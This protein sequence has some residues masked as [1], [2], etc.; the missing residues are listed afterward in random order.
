MKYAILLGGIEINSDN[1]GISI[2]E[3]GNG[4]NTATIA[5]G[6]YYL[7]GDGAS[8]DFCLALKTALEAASASANTY[9]VTVTTDGTT[10]SWDTNPAN[11]S[12]KVRIARLTGSATFEI[13]WLDALTTFDESLLGFAVEKGAADANPEVSTLSPEA[14][15]VSSQVHRDIIRSAS[16]DLA[17]IKVNSGDT[18]TIK[19]SKKFKQAQIVSMWVD[20]RR[21]LASSSP[22]DE[23]AAMESFIDRFSA[24]QPIEAH[25]Q[26]LLSSAVTT[27]SALSSSTSIGGTWRISDESANFVPARE[28]LGLDLFNFD[29]FLS[30]AV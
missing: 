15:W 24:G 4:T 20:A 19:R 27:L 28:M 12:A 8:G 6:T 13:N 10:A 21:V 7:R 9:G 30:G 14:V 23:G 16:W 3:T 5:A 29:T 1:W 17:S 11:V 18:R 25:E 26:T 2:T 22:S